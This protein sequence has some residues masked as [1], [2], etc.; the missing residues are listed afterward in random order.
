MVLQHEKPEKG[1]REREREHEY[2]SVI[3]KTREGGK[4]RGR[5]RE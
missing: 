4:P 2:I 5:E 3:E 1:G